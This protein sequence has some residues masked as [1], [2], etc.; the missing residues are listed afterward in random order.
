MS[1]QDEITGLMLKI[2][3][4]AMR[5]NCGCEVCVLG[6]KLAE[7]LEDR[8]GSS[9]RKPKGKVVKPAP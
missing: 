9:P 7:T 8:L 6:K 4:A 2:A 5:S 3:F 1:S